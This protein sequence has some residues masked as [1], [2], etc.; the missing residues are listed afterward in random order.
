MVK[1]ITGG[2]KAKKFGRKS[3][4]DTSRRVRYIENEGEIYGIAIQML[5]NGMF[6]V[7]CTDDITRT[8]VIRGKFSGKNKGSHRISIGVWVL[9]GLYEWSSKD[10]SQKCDLLEVYTSNEKEKL[11]QTNTNFAALQKEE[12]T[13]NN[14][15]SNT[16]DDVL[17]ETDSVVEDEEF[18]EFMKGSSSGAAV[19]I[20]EEEFIISQA[21]VEEFEDHFVKLK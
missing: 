12:N 16:F 6:R 14:I 4:S 1:N 20:P 9:V 11:L 8:C 3:F 5:G 13:L 10:K 18:K 17:F 15:D 19:L 7:K 2:N 21:E